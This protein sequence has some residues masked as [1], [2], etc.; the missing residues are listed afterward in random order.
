MGFS[1]SHLPSPQSPGEGHFPES[2]GSD[3]VKNAGFLQVK[4]AYGVTLENSYI[5]FLSFIF[6][7][8]KEKSK[9][10]DSSIV[11]TK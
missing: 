8:L 11:K 5:T 6:P 7:D 3:V 2:Q 9:T 4:N 1:P 10:L